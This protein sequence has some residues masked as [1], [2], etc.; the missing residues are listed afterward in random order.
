MKN[1]RT[2]FLIMALFL[3]VVLAFLLRGVF[4][5]LVIYP[6]AKLWFMIRGYYGSMAQSAYWPLVLIAILVLGISSL[7][8]FEWN[9]QLGGDRQIELRGEVQQMAFWLERLSDLR[10]SLGHNPY[11]RWYVARTL[12]DLAVDILHRRGADE[13]RSGQLRGP[14]WA[15][16]P[17]VQKYLEIALQSNPATFAR[18][19]SAASMSTLP[20]VELVIQY[21]E[22]YVENSK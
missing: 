22:S 17:E 7:R 10:D 19:L 15:P 14:G 20:D 18:M 3:A 12:A 9:F 5:A 2:L 8:I 11:P 16:P 6:L 4:D 13:A 1:R 21:L